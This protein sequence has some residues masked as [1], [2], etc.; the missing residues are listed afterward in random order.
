MEAF[1]RVRKFYLYQI[2]FC[3]V[4]LLIASCTRQMN[5]TFE[6]PAGRGYHAMA[7]DSESDK[8]ILFS[9]QT[10]PYDDPRSLNNETWAY[11]P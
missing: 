6:R 11:D 1:M 5:R 3:L 4:I 9:G 8:I 2:V 10:G 7:Y